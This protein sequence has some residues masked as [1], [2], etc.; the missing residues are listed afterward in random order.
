MKKTSYIIMALLLAVNVQAQLVDRERLNE[1]ISELKGLSEQHVLC[2]SENFNCYATEESQVTSA[3]LAFPPNL[4][5]FVMRDGEKMPLAGIYKADT[6][7]RFVN[8]ISNDSKGYSLVKGVF[9]KYYDGEAEDIFGIPLMACNREDGEEQTLFMDE[10]NTLLIRDDGQDVEL[11]YGNFNLMNTLQNVLRS[12]AEITDEEYIDVEMFGGID[13]GVHLDMNALT[14]HPDNPY[15]P[16]ADSE[17]I[18]A[19]A[20]KIFKDNAELLERR[21]AKAESEEEREEI[22]AEIAAF[23][24]E[25]EES[26][27]DLEKELSE[28]DEPSF[29]EIFPGTNEHF[30]AIPKVPEHL[31][32]KMKPYAA[33]GVY[34]W[35]NLTGFTHGAK[36]SLDQISCIITPQDVAMQCAIRHYQRDKSLDTLYIGFTPQYKEMAATEY[37]GGMPAVLYRFS[38]N[39]KGY[40]QMLADLGYFFSLKL[41]EMHNGLEAIQQSENNGKRFVQLWGEGGILMCIFDSPADK[42]CHMS[43]IIGGTDGFEQAVNEFVFGGEKDFAK[44]CNIIINSDLSNNSYGIHFTEDEYFFAGKPHKNGVHIDFGYARRFTGV[45]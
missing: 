5:N 29:I 16:S 43:I 12:V 39:E 15:L 7:F 32:G 27:G 34:D 35:I 18:M 8:V 14:R 33:S 13:F 19:L 30:V 9:D 38:Q 25:A 36:G 21:L 11:I 22:A 20:Q 23:K 1:F 37:Q 6:T 41:G 10:N 2:E 24:K 26:L 4:V 17:S 31:K 45:E 40:K 42:Y 28:L 44:K 3:H